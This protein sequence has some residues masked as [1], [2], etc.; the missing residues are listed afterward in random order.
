MEFRKS[1]VLQACVYL[2][3]MVL[4][5]CGGPGQYS[6]IHPYLEGKPFQEVSVD[7][8][9]Y[10]SVQLRGGQDPNLALVVA[11]SGG[12]FRA[13]SFAAAVLVGLEELKSRDDSVS[14]ALNEV[15]Y[16]SSVSGGGFAV[17]AY[18]STLHDY[19]YFTG[20]RAGY[21]FAEAMRPADCKCPYSK[22]PSAEQTS[23]PC[24]RRHLQ[25]VYSDFIR[26]VLSMLF[27]WNRLGLDDRAFRFELAI[28]DDVLGN[29]WRK[30]KLRSLDDEEVFGEAD[31][32]RNASLLLSD[33]FVD[34]NDEH[35]M[36]SMPYWIPNATVYETGTIFA[37]TP[38]QLRLYRING[39]KHRMQTRQFLP[40]DQSYSD[41]I[42]G[43]PVSV[44]VASSGNFPF[45]LSPNVITNKLDPN[46]SYMYLLD[47]GLADNLGVITAVRI[48]E[49]E[50]YPAV[51]RKALIV[52]DAYQG[53]LSPFSSSS[54]PPQILK[55]VRRSMDIS[56]DSWR[57]R[58]RELVD[59]FCSSRGI[60][61][62]YLSFD[63]LVDADF[64]DLREF[65]LTQKDMN[66][67]CEHKPKKC[68][69]ATPFY[70]ARSISMTA[71]VKIGEEGLEYKLPAEQQNLLFAAGRYIVDKRRDEILAAL[72]WE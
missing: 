17:G 29:R 27:P 5:G 49:K 24:I 6:L 64:N 7:L 60:R 19:M 28:D 41:F 34:A 56:L 4:A 44:G 32:G 69:K 15:D 50:N 21:S 61:S 2:F 1:R 57:W 31:M 42:R 40:S 25:G 70:L 8:S 30:R 38:D 13:S 36:V 14:N 22:V 16:F 11:A 39:Y 20:T 54:K 68:P 51:E 63:D 53:S 18:I 67:L 55:T 43:W 66:L 45:A 35:T 26:D 52:I 58:Y 48:L 65:G 33:I 3:I 47:G 46:N 71:P 10:K 23:D 59:S 9:A 72:G 12:G 37:F 62:V